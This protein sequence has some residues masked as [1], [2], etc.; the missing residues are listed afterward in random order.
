MK[1]LSTDKT[2]E[3]FLDDG[4]S[5]GK[6]PRIPG[7]GVRVTSK[8]VKTFFYDYTFQGRRRQY[9]LGQFPGTSASEARKRASQA[10]L[11]VQNMSDPQAAVEERR[12]GMTVTMMCKRYI[13]EHLFGLPVG[14]IEKRVDMNGQDLFTLRPKQI[15]FIMENVGYNLS[16][17][18]IYDQIRQIR[19][20][21]LPELG[22]MLVSEVRGVHIKAALK[23]L[24]KTPVQANRLLATLSKMFNLSIEWEV[25]DNNPCATA[26][27]N[28]ETSRAAYFSEDQMSDL[29]GVLNSYENH[30]QYSAAV[31]VVRVAMFTGSRFGE[32]VKAEVKHFHE[33][34]SGL[35]MWHKPS[36]NTKQGTDER[37]PV[38]DSVK[39]VVK[40]RIAYAKFK[41]TKYLFPSPIDKNKPLSSIKKSWKTF[42][43]EAGVSGVNLHD[44]RRTFGTY[45][46]KAEGKDKLFAISKMLGHKSIK[47]TQIYLGVE[48]ETLRPT[49]NIM[50]GVINDIA[51][52]KKVDG[53]E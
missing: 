25:R 32:I 12:E 8:G 51:D 23:R 17:K 48:P 28:K 37:V 24:Y 21:V 9:S 45:L 46:L 42:M 33:D 53:K 13:E 38:S 29:V 16:Y 5:T 15:E 52:T 20:Y 19:S 39:Q 36:S 26:K 4:P 50:E 43:N 11:D 35:M 27:K 3:K 14:E 10:R 2:L 30:P 40:E 49:A 7:F 6:S 1:R 31:S 41:R 18:S 44:I 47:T 34:S 22:L